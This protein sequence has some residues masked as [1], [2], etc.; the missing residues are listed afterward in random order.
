MARKFDDEEESKST[1]SMNM[2]TTLADFIFNREPGLL[3][4]MEIMNGRNPLNFFQMIFEPPKIEEGKRQLE[5]SI[6]WPY[7]ERLIYLIRKFKV[8]SVE[9]QQEII[10]AAKLKIWWRGDEPGQFSM[11]I[12]ETLYYRE[13]PENE[14]LAYRKNA[15]I[16]ALGFMSRN[17]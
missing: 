13:L 8:Q 11:I 7:A 1:T 10:D 12:D 17:G 4:P 15:M 2:S 14:K 9:S 6:A 5:K 3:T 16:Q